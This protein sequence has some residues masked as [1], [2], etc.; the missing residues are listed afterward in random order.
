MDRLRKLE[1][2]FQRPRTPFERGVGVTGTGTNATQ[3]T[4]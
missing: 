3:L 1:R 4:V 2:G